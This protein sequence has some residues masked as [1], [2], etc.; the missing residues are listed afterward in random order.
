[1]LL[2]FIIFGVIAIS[3]FKGKFISCVTDDIL[4]ATIPD[5]DNTFEIFYKWDCLNAGSEWQK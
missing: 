4:Y 1:M 3:Y 5:Y 2:F